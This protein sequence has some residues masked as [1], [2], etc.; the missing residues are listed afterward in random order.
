MFEL[1][2]YMKS[3]QLIFIVSFFCILLPFSAQAQ[4]DEINISAAF[5]SSIDLRIASGANINFV[6]ST[7]NDYQTGKTGKSSFEVASSVSFSIAISMTPF[8]NENGD[9]IDLK[10]LLFRVGVP[11]SRMGEE[12]NRW[13][14][15]Q[16]NTGTGWALVRGGGEY[17]SALHYATTE[18]RTILLPG[19]TGNAGSYEDNT[20]LLKF[21]FGDYNRGLVNL[22]PLLDQNIA[23]GTYTCTV[24]L[25]AIPEA[26]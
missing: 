20:Y 8:T 9:E 22:P 21:H 24:T 16:A 14:F 5:S 12:H 4:S 7:L 25:E 1:I 23:P 11:D 26:L 19:P 17:L 6:F 3:R 13:D 2:Q 18:P 15:A 10:N